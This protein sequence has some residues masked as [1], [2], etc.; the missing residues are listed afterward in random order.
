M[1][2]ALWTWISPVSPEP[3]TAPE[4]RSTTRSATS[5]TGRP[6]ESRRQAAGSPTG[7]AAM[8]GTSLV[9]YAGSQRTP[10]RALTV[11]ATD[12]V[13]GVAPHMT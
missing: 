8:T 2:D 6:A 11:S 12:A 3:S 7:L 9:P 10:V 1:A 5:P 4:S 13:T